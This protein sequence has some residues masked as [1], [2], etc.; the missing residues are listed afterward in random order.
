MSWANDGVSFFFDEA[1]IPPNKKR[2]TA[3]SLDS[4]MRRN[5]E[6]NRAQTGVRPYEIAGH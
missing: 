4:G 1:V 6:Q 2:R 5:D 3:N